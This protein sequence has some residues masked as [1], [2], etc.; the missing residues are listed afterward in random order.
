MSDS[1]SEEAESSEDSE[2]YEEE[3]KNQ[4]N[5]YEGGSVSLYTLK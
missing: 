3:T 2:Y 4:I 5:T 1:E